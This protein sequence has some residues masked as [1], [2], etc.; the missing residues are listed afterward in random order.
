M[1]FWKAE[2]FQKF[3]YP[4]AECALAGIIPDNNY[5]LVQ[6]LS[7]LT[8]MTFSMRDRFDE[9]MLHLYNSLIHRYVN[10]VK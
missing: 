9:N 8:E 5:H 6:T 2:E 1:H 4:A 3:M 7:R 10:L